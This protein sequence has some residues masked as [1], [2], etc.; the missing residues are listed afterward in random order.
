MPYNLAEIERET[1]ARVIATLTIEE[2]A[3]VY[4]RLGYTAARIFKLFECDPQILGI[5]AEQLAEKL[6]R[7]NIEGLL[8]F[9][10]TLSRQSRSPSSNE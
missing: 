9:F 8:R 1:R 2:V 4:F 5:T 6:P 10:I 3:E 7:E